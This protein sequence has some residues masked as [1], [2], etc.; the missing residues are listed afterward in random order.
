[1]SMHKRHKNQI[2]ILKAI[3]QIMNEHFQKE[4]TIV[5]WLNTFVAHFRTCNRP[6]TCIE[7]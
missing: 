5:L 3:D 1:M 6:D 4:A 7:A 2:E